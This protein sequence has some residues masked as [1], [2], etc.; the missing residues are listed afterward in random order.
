MSPSS[1]ADSRLHTNVVV[2]GESRSLAILTLILNQYIIGHRLEDVLLGL[3]LCFPEVQVIPS[4]G[5]LGVCSA[6]TADVFPLF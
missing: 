3:E 2:A 5:N 6:T 1:L 4:V